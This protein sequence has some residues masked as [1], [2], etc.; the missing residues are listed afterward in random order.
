MKVNASVG[1]VVTLRLSP[2]SEVAFSG[3]PGT[4]LNVRDQTTS[5]TPSG[6]SSVNMAYL[7]SSQTRRT[8]AGG[9]SYQDDSI[10]VSTITGAMT[11]AGS[12]G[13]LSATYSTNGQPMSL[14]ADGTATFQVTLTNTGTSTWAAGGPTPYHLRIAFEPS[15]CND[16]PVTITAPATTGGMKLVFQMVHEGYAFFPQ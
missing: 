11:P 10:G 8:A 4:R 6:G 15:T 2:F 9:L 5:I 16:I 1:R 13:S 3:C 14:A 7:D 12:G